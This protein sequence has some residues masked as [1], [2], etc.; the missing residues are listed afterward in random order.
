MPCQTGHDEGKV[1]E[2]RAACV[3]WLA[4]MPKRGGTTGIHL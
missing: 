2:A 1:E 4:G 3:V